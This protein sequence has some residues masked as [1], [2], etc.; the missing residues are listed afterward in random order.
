MFFASSLPAFYSAVSGRL[1]PAS[2]DAKST[3]SASSAPQVLIFF[4]LS[5][6]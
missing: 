1:S 6:S 2:V 4:K 3:R 5:R